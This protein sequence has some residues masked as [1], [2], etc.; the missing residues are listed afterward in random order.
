MASKPPDHR[1]FTPRQQ[2]ENARFLAAL[3]RTGN[4][5]LTCRELGVHRACYTRRR[6]RCAAFATEWD[7]VLAA[8]HAAFQLAGGE[9]LPE[10]RPGTGR[11]TSRRPV[12]GPNAEREEGL[13]TRGGEPMIV[14]QANGRLQLRRAPPGRMTDAAEQLYLAALSATANVRLA[15][16]AT[17]FAHS[18]FYARRARHGSFAK[19]ERLA[20][21]IACDRMNWALLQ[22]A[23]ATLSPAWRIQGPDAFALPAMTTGECLQLI[24]MHQN[25]A[26]KH[27]GWGAWSNWRATA[28]GSAEAAA[29]E[30]AALRDQFS[31]ERARHY[32]ATGSWRLPD[33]PAPPVLPDLRV[34]MARGSKARVS[35]TY[36]NDRA[37]FGGWRIDDWEKRRRR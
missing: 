4:V 5:R 8:A 18:S 7:M 14:R 29:A 24:V 32:E 9:R 31:A 15:A 6:A 30:A 16:A 20:I 37:L 17:G 27:G 26:V 34:V 13:R 12:E 3:R 1:P 23:H 25:A 35:V 21:E 2:R 19:E 10:I 33:E 36:S 11:G 28:G 22:R